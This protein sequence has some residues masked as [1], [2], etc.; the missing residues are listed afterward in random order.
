MSCTDFFRNTEIF[1][2]GHIFCFN[3]GNQG[4]VKP[5]GITLGDPY[6]VSRVSRDSAEE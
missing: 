6:L 4:W 5:V 1:F 3:L 2:K